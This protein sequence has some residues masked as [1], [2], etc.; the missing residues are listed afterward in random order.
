MDFQHSAMDWLPT[1]TSGCPGPHLWHWAQPR[2]GHDFRRCKNDSYPLTSSN[3][4]SQLN[5]H[6]PKPPEILPGEKPTNVCMW[7]TQRQQLGSHHQISASHTAL[8]HWCLWYLSIS[9]IITLHHALQSVRTGS[10]HNFNAQSTL[11]TLR[12]TI[13]YLVMMWKE[14]WIIGLEASNWPGTGDHSL[15]WPKGGQAKPEM[16]FSNAPNAIISQILEK[17]QAES[18]KK[19]EKHSL[20]CSTYNQSFFCCSFL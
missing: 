10:L 15:H 14:G 1:T 11:K 3:A 7:W 4:S 20:F 5:S 9:V 18:T 6:S 8:K 16:P 13:S 17:F 19:Q 2:M 12:S